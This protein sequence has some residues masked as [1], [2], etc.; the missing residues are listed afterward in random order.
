MTYV[1]DLRQVLE[2]YKTARNKIHRFSTFLQAGVAS[3]SL[4]STVH[5]FLHGIDPPQ[6]LQTFGVCTVLSVL[7]SGLFY[8]FF[9]MCAA[10][11]TLQDAQDFLHDLDARLRELSITE[12]CN[13]GVGT[14]DDESKEVV[15]EEDE[16]NVILINIMKHL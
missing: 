1:D 8:R 4:G 16:E 7:Y 14:D 2:P 12:R 5:L 13:K 6:F 3:A 15:N 9:C 11:K 10:Q